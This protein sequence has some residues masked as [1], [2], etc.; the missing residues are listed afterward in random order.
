MNSNPSPSARHL[1]LFHVMA[2]S[3]FSERL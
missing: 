2:Y 3:V 1:Q